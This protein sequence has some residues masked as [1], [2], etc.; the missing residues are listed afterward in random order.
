MLA[1]STRSLEPLDWSFD[2]RNVGVGPVR[3]KSGAVVKK[4]KR[5]D[6][7][8]E[9]GDQVSGGLG[10]DGAGN[11]GTTPPETL[12]MM[13]FSVSR[14]FQ[15]TLLLLSVVA[16]VQIYSVLARSTLLGDKP[17]YVSGCN[18]A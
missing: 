16:C 5:R 11:H 8:V 6:V 17:I 3:V 9:M 13:T 15:R 14:R 18:A 7:G 4:Q 1:L 2:G 10:S 12:L